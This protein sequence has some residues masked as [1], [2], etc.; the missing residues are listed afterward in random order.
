MNPWTIIGWVIVGGAALVVALC[1]GLAALTWFAKTRMHVRTR[2]DAPKLGDVWIQDGA[3][4]T[5]DRIADNG[6][7]VI[8]SGPASWSD[9]PEEWRARVRNRKLWR[10]SP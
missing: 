6:R 7:I 1:I 3:P 10:S 9:S 2:R 8:K 5:I 4:L